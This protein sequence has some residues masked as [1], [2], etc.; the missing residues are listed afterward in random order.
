M[1]RKLLKYDLRA[2]YR[3][4]CIFYGII[5][6]CALLAKLFANID[7]NGFTFFLKEFFKGATTG[8]S[9]GALINNAMN[10]WAYCKQNLYGDRGYLMHTLPVT[11]GTLLASKFLTALI[12]SFTTILLSVVA[13]LLV[14]GTPEIYDF[15]RQNLSL[16]LSILLVFYLETVFIMQCGISGIIIGHKF[17]Y[18]KVVLSIA[19]GF[20]IFLF[21]NTLTVLCVFIR[22]RFDGSL[23][24]IFD[25][26]SEVIPTSHLLHDLLISGAAIY[27]IYTGCLYLF[28]YRL[29]KTGIDID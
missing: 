14:Q 21:A 18:N 13:I 4:L 24:W 16:A 20:G 2:I 8:L 26:S 29:L 5:I 15:L 28:N 27:A 17:N 11:R 3:P 22:S 19:F 6:V 1:L 23:A 7:T 9:I 25:G 10:I 12:T